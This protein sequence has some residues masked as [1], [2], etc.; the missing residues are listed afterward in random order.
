MVN[1]IAQEL[2]TRF[3]RI[4]LFDE[5]MSKHT[6]IHIGGR[7][8]AFIEP[9]NIDDLKAVLKILS[10]R[11]K[12][13]QIVGN[14]SNLIFDSGVMDL[15]V[16]SLVKLKG[17][18]VD[19]KHGLVEAMAGE[20]LSSCF[21]KCAAAGLSGFEYLCGIPATVGGAVAGNAGAFGKTISEFLL[22]LTV[23][24]EKYEIKTIDP[25][26]LVFDYRKSGIKEKKYIIVSAVFKLDRLAPSTIYS[27]AQKF[28]SKRKFTQPSEYSA[29]CVFKKT[30][31]APAGFL[32][33]EVGLK[34]QRVGGCEISKIHANFI[35][36]VGG[37][38]STDYKKLE[39]IIKRK[40]KSKY[41]IVLEKEVE[42]VK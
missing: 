33:D 25:S 40:V 29:G 34:G 10:T 12:R 16:V 15:Y 4:V 35:I 41:N 8:K 42:Y 21:A 39:K 26:E 37:G 20:M 2:L 28:A 22:S 18:S 19:E 17:I 23:L 11:K 14:G 31:I 13:I 32:I 24:D 27:I 7:V 1:Q 5:E 36:N 9:E 3:E 38:T 30:E 6:T